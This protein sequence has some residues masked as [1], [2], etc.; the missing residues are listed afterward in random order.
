M[1]LP[2]ILPPLI[3]ALAGC[4]AVH[5][6]HGEHPYLPVRTFEPDVAL[7]ASADGRLVVRDRCIRL[8]GRKGGEG[9]LVVWP[10]GSGL[11]SDSGRLA[12]SLP[13]GRAPLEVGD[14]VRLGGG[15]SESFIA[16]RIE[17]ADAARCTGPYFYA[18]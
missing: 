11:I 4:T 7:T 16:S 3:L 13:A 17:P 2:S 15:V 5:M 10:K 12:I 14:R 18:N 8:I 9:V 1:R 6:Y